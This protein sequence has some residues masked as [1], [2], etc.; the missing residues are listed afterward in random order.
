M[1]TKPKDDSN[2]LKRDR[3]L[4]DGYMKREPPSLDE[5]SNEWPI[6]HDVAHAVYT[7]ESR[8]NLSFMDEYIDPSSIY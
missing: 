8:A 3:H 5:I 6:D 4:S 7:I 1:D 2:I